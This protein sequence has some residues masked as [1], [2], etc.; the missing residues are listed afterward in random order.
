MPV[1]PSPTRQRSMLQRLRRGLVL[2]G[3]DNEVLCFL[4]RRRWA[5]ALPLHDPR[6]GKPLASR[7]WQITAAGVAVAT[8]TAQPQRRPFRRVGRQIDIEDA[9]AATSS[10]AA[11]G[12]S[13]SP[14]PTPPALTM[15][16]G[17]TAAALGRATARGTKTL[18][19]ETP[20]P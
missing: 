6:N 4:E 18:A 16:A 20:T 9:I 3:H 12:A 1:A 2:A 5:H 14:H 13:P 17:A 10:G 8:G 15:P 19:P 7:A 11:P